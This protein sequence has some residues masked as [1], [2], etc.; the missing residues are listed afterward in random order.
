[1]RFFASPMISLFLTTS[2]QEFSTEL[3]SSLI[4]SFHRELNKYQNGHG[5]DV[6]C[7]TGEST[8]QLEKN[9]PDIR[10]TGIDKNV[11]AIDVAQKRY[12]YSDFCHVDIEK[13]SNSESDMFQIIQISN[14][15]NLEKMLRNTYHLLHEDGMMIVRYHD[16]DID[17]IHQL[18]EKNN[19]FRAT[20]IYGTT[21][22]K[23]HLFKER[24]TAIIFK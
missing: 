7:W 1:M 24:N 19:R 6:N 8:K 12:H 21:L 9:F 20:M 13:E 5:L 23:M 17:Y 15:N 2:R 18:L 4:P 14:Y 10:F 16:K 11:R 22:H 3:K